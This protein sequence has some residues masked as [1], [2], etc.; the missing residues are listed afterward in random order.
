[1]KKLLITLYLSLLASSAF[2]QANSTANATISNGL[3][4]SVGDQQQAVTFNTSPSAPVVPTSLPGLPSAQIYTKPDAPTQARGIPMSMGAKQVCGVRWT[5]DAR[6]TSSEADG[7]SG[8]TKVLWNAFPDYQRLA[9]SSSVELAEI[10]PPMFDTTPLRNVRCLGVVTILTKEGGEKR[11]DFGTIETDLADFLFSNLK[12]VGKVR[13][14]TFPEAVGYPTGVATEGSSFGIGGIVGNLLALKTAGVVNPS[15]A[16][17]SSTATPVA[18]LG[19]T[20][21]VLAEEQ[22]GGIT[23]DPNALA[24]YYRGQSYGNGTPPPAAAV[25]SAPK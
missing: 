13:L 3:M 8:K 12:G 21:L 23:L 17:G 14:M 16:T 24:R 4:G 7:V 15:F 10:I 1:M 6:G 20:I 2:A 19:A 22:E 25:Q 18:W 5:R 9:A 11:T